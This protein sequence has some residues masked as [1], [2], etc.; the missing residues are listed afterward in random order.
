V[1]LSSAS[2]LNVTFI[3]VGKIVLHKLKVRLDWLIEETFIYSHGRG[4]CS[5]GA[6][7]CAGVIEP[8]AGTIAPPCPDMSPGVLSMALEATADNLYF[9]VSSRGLCYNT[10]MD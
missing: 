6:P 8:V 3:Y 10:Q 5:D 9:Q 1:C 2:R 7:V 4:I